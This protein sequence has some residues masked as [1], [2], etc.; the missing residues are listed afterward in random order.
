MRRILVACLAGL[1]PSIA[2]AQEPGAVVIGRFSAF[3][4]FTAIV[5]GFVLAIAFQLLLTVLSAATGLSVAGPLDEEKGKEGGKERS[6]GKAARRVTSA[7]G[8]WTLVTTSVALFFA[9]WLAVELSLTVSTLVGI[10]LGLVT[11]GLF[12]LAIMTLEVSAVSSLVGS[13]GRTALAGLRS[14]YSSTTALFAPS[15]GGGRRASDVAEK[16]TEV[17]RERLVGE[18]QDRQLGERIRE[19]VGNV[20]KAVPPDP[21]TVRVRLRERLD[22]EE[23]AALS[24]DD[25]P[26]WDR[27]RVVQEVATRPQI[28]PELARRRVEATEEAVRRLRDEAI[29]REPEAR[30]E[31]QDPKAPPPRV[32]PVSRVVRERAVAKVQSVAAEPGLSSV[33]MDDVRDRVVALFHDPS[34]SFDDIAHR[35]KTMDRA[36]LKEQVAMRTDLTE[37]DVDRLIN[38]MEEG[39]DQV[40]RRAE[41]ARAEVQRRLDEARDYALHRAEEARKVTSTAA[42]WS[43]AT[44]LAS[45]AAAALGGLV[46]VLVG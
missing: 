16:V 6:A 20:G 7:F 8:I 13:L 10:V 37:E 30:M 43:F 32:G 22:A 39:R 21:E 27:E 14:A 38:R 9:S 40:M 26:L 17:V 41:E 31:G 42:W 1:A 23:I 33:S 19:L 46:A 2:L 4:F 24:M 11:W 5:A 29:T 44:A 35:A 15:P 12:Y 18:A 3:N 36:W 28:G 25:G 45:G 34:S